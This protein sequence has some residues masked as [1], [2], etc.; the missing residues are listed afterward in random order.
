[1]ATSKNN[2]PRDTS[3]D[4]SISLQMGRVH[5]ICREAVTAVVEPLGLTQSRWTALVHIDYLNEG[6]TQL[7]LANSLGIEMPSLTRTLKQL[8]AQNLIVRRVGETDKRSKNIY[9]TQAGRDLI[10]RLQMLLLDIKE[11][12]YGS[13]SQQQMEIIANGLTEIEKNARG[14]INELSENRVDYDA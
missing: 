11:K 8:E 3:F 6:V 7:E 5:R 1:M 14:L 4:L 13:L 9:F 12:L 10:N 2:N